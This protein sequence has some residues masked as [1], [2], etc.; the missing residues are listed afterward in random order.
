[1]ES[2]EST[3]ILTGYGTDLDFPT[4]PTANTSAGTSSNCKN[5]FDISKDTLL[6]QLGKLK[7]AIFKG[8]HEDD[9]KHLMPIGQMGNYQDALTRRET[10]RDVLDDDKAKRPMFGNPFRLEKGPKLAIDEADEADGEAAAS[11]KGFKRRRSASP[12]PHGATSPSPTKP[13]KIQPLHPNTAMPTAPPNTT[14]PPLLNTLVH[15]KVTQKPAKQLPTP[16][17]PVLSTNKPMPSKQVGSSQPINQTSSSALNTAE[18]NELKN[19]IIKELKKPSKQYDMI[20]EKLKLLRGGTD[21]KKAVVQEIIQQA[22]KYKKAA[23]IG[24][25]EQYERNLTE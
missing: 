25:L 17:L 12:R 15:K 20:F 3:E 24:Q 18:N 1:V 16:P 8:T 13:S 9:G 4:T 6:D 23:L 5:P 19:I 2:P 22:K 10:L 14:T 21:T 7:E 11:R